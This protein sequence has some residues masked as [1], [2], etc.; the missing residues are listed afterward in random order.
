MATVEA[1]QMRHEPAHGE[2]GAAG[3][4][5]ARPSRLLQHAQ[6]ALLERI[7]RS[8][9]DLPQGL[10]AFIQPQAGPRL[11]EKLHT[12]MILQAPKLAAD[13]AMGSAEL[14][15]RTRHRAETR[16]RLKG[17]EG[18]KRRKLARHD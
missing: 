12:R 15:A 13:R 2:G 7:E 11:L 14:L 5:H 4:M 10:A 16:R 18:G 3:H 17:P 9:D 6:P 8:G 1:L